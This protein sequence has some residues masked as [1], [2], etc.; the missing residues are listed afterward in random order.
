MA[1][2]TAPDVTSK[3]APAIHAGVNAHTSY[4]SL[5][6]KTIT[7]S[8][9]ISMIAL[10]GGARVQHAYYTMNNAPGG[11]GADIAVTI[12]TADTT[13]AVVIQTAS[14]AQTLSYNP[15]HDAALYKT[16]ASSQ[17]RVLLKGTFSA[18]VSTTIAVTR[19]YTTDEEAD[20]GS[21]SP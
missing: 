17:V 11:A 18:S 16:T 6:A 9:S 21:S 7:G 19:L 2:F 10:P 5:E 14:A 8:Q 20:S 12:S 1:H 3:A 15:T 4:Y 13:R